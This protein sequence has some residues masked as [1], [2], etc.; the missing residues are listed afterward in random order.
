MLTTL[1][2]KYSDEKLK[3]IKLSIQERGDTGISREEIEKS[4]QNEGLTSIANN[5]KGNLEKGKVCLIESQKFCTKS[6]LEKIIDH[7]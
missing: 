4:L 6:L 7:V 5:L 2:T 1:L 3:Q